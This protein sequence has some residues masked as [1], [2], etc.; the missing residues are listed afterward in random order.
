MVATG[1][2]ASAV[3][4]PP[5]P[6]SFALPALPSAVLAAGLSPEEAEATA[7]V[8]AGLGLPV[9]AEATFNL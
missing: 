8:L 5:K 1:N 7:P 4:K 3:G 2:S 6:P 9:F